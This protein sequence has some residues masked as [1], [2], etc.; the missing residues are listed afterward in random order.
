MV[1]LTHVSDEI[2]AFLYD[3]RLFNWD[4]GRGTGQSEYF[5]Q[6]IMIHQ[7]VFDNNKKNK[8]KNNNNNNKCS[9]GCFT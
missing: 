1:M 7:N 2:R 4:S 5:R 9:W 3:I 8:N 6:R